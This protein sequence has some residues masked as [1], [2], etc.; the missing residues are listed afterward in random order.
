MLSE[1]K[2]TNNNKQ[3][4]T[5][6]VIPESSMVQRDKANVHTTAINIA[7]ICPIFSNT[8]VNMMQ[9]DICKHP[10]VVLTSNDY[11]FFIMISTSMVAETKKQVT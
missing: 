5:N 2:K 10:L 3:K 11:L 4:T 9:A 8:L 6:Y 1:E 7:V